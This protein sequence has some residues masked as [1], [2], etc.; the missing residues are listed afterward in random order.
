MTMLQLGDL[1]GVIGVLIVSL[2]KFCP[3]MLPRASSSGI[4]HIQVGNTSL[5]F[6]S[7]RL[8]ALMEGSVP[9]LLKVCRGVVESLGLF[10]FGGHLKHPVTAHPKVD[11]VSGEMHSFCYRYTPLPL[12]RPVVAT[13]PA[14][15][16]WSTVALALMRVRIS[17]RDACHL[18]RHASHVTTLLLVIEHLG[19]VSPK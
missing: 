4:E 6:H 9:Y 3:W 16:C 17:A 11:P 18:P 10:T 12:P 19:V 14:C 2:N 1:R 15:T 8:L 7:G 5:V 13:C